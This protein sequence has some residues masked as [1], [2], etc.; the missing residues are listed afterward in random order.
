M[1]N[2]EQEQPIMQ[3]ERAPR[4]Y[5]TG[6]YEPARGTS[7][8]Q[9]QATDVTIEMIDLQRVRDHFVWSVFNTVY[10][11]ICCLGLLALSYSVE[12]RDH[13][14]RGDMRGAKKQASRSR[15]LNIATTVLSILT[16]IIIFTLFFNGILTLKP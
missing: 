10:M 9:V 1:E 7:C 12:S 14:Q 6:A 2:R 4:S 15:S 5:G 11:N 8:A 16:V 3:S 13:K